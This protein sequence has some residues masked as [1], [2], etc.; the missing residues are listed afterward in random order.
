MKRKRSF[1]R[2]DLA[3]YQLFFLAVNSGCRFSQW[4]QTF[5]ERHCIDAFFAVRIWWIKSLGILLQ[6]TDSVLLAISQVINVFFFFFIFLSQLTSHTFTELCSILV[7]FASFL[8][9]VLTLITSYTPTSTD[10]SHADLSYCLV[11]PWCGRGHSLSTSSRWW[12]WFF[13]HLS[14]DRQFK[15]KYDHLHRDGRKVHRR[16]FSRLITALCTQIVL[17]RQR[18]RRRLRLTKPRGR[19]GFFCRSVSVSVYTANLLWKDY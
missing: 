17:I 9:L 7:R 2:S 13:W 4:K 5:L 18:R 16:W 6:R 8:R 14:V 19:T 10:S 12:W 3:A 1:R 11:P 15:C